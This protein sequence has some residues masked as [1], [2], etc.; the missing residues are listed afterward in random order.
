MGPSDK[1]IAVIYQLSEMPDKLAGEVCRT[2]VAHVAEKRKSEHGQL[3]LSRLVFL[4]GH[5]AICQLNYM[6]ISV[7][8]KL[9]RRSTLTEL[10]KEADKKSKEKQKSGRRKSSV[11]GGSRGNVSASASFI[12]ASAGNTP[13]ATPGAT[14]S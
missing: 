13:R 6:D 7:F 9:K 8:N 10:K 11:V 1:V 5:V 12:S 4:F 2:L 14:R 3:H